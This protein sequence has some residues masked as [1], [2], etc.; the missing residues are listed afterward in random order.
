MIAT[1]YSPATSSSAKRSDCSASSSSFWL[2]SASV[3]GMTRR[4]SVPLS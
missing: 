1:S 3:A 4:L 2:M